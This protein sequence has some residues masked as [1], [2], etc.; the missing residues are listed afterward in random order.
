MISVVVF[1][2]DYAHE[3]VLR[4]LVRRLANENNLELDL[5]VLS[6]SGGHGRMFGELRQFVAKLKRGSAAVPDL[7]IVAR[8]ANCEGY[9]NRA[10]EIGNA[11]EDYDGLAVYAIP[12]P[13]I[14]RWL[15]LDPKAFKKVLKRGCN[16]PDQKCDRARFKRFFED[17]IR[18][19][20]VEPLLGGIEF[21]ED[22]VK[23]M[24]LDQAAAND[25]AF[26]H[27]LSDL[28]RAL[29]RLSR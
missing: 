8:D 15:L 6:S 5:R 1:G 18:T 4:T 2:E 16:L 25:T 12:D 11:L 10:K 7:F 3:V 9:A 23:D 26:A 27:L 20:G 19:A 29:Q 22:L 21:A 24:R 13:H 17:A 14:E 28:R